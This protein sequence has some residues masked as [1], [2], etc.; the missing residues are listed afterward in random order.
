MPQLIGYK[1][2]ASYPHDPTAFTQGLLWHEGALYEGTGLEGRSSIRKLEFPSGRVLRQKPLNSQF[3]GEG[4][5]LVG[6]RL[7]QLTWQ[8]GRGFVYDLDTFRQ[9]G[10]FRYDT[11]GWGL[12]YDGKMLIMSDGTDTLTYLDPETFE[13]KKRLRVTFGGQPLKHL[14]ELEWINGEIWANVWMTNQIARISPTTGAVKTYLDLTGI[15]PRAQQTGSED[16]L[17][18]IAYDPVKKRI[19]VTG[20]LWPRIFEIRVLE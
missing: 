8:S 11:E 10:E 6:K 9:I 13:P 20:K 3:F 16:V 19:W 1:V 17:N 14:N 4:L 5:A 15:L 7:V 2:V 18:G 12:T